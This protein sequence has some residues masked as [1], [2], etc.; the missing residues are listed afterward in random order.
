[1]QI[2]CWAIPPII[3]TA[4]NE[5]FVTK[6]FKN[7]LVKIPLNNSKDAAAFEE[8]LAQLHKTLRGEILSLEIIATGQNVGF[9]FSG[10]TA[11]CEVATGEIYARIPN[12]DIIEIDDYTSNIS[13]KA[14]FNSVELGLVKHDLFPLKTFEEFEGD[15][16]SGLLSVLSH[17]KPGE[18]VIIEI[19][20]RPKPDSGLHHFWSALYRKMDRLRHLFR[21]KYWFKR[22][23]GKTFQAKIHEKSHEHLFF[24]NIRLAALSNRSRFDVQPRLESVYGIMSNF[25]TTD[26][27]QLKVRTIKNGQQ[28]IKSFH[29]RHLHKPFLLSSRELAAMFHLPNEHASPNLI[30]ILASKGAPPATLPTDESDSEI[31]FFGHTNFRDQRMPFGIK[32]ADRHRHLHILGKSGYGKSKLLELLIQSDI[33]AGRGVGVLDPHGDLVDSVLRC[34]PRNRIEDVVIVDASDLDFP[35]SFNPFELVPF[36]LKTRVSL[37][38]VDIFKRLFGPDWSPRLEHLLRYTMLA[39]LDTPETTLPSILKMLSDQSYRQLVGNN[40]KDKAVKDFWLNEFASWSDKYDREAIAPLFNK[41]SQF[42]ATNMMHNI[43]GQPANRINFKEI[44]DQR[45]I[46][47]IKI[48]RGILGEDNTRLLGSLAIIK[49]FQA[50]IDRAKTPEAERVDFYLHLDEFHNFITGSAEEF[51][52]EARKYHLSL[53]LAHQSLSHLGDQNCKALLGNLGSLISFRVGGEDANVIAKE[54]TPRFSASDLINLGL[55]D[56]Y[57]KMSVDG[58]VKEPFSARTLTLQYPPDSYAQ[59]CIEHSRLHYCQPIETAQQILAKDSKV[60]FQK[61]NL[62]STS[63]P[64]SQKFDFDETLV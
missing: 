59:E 30:K 57:I 44:I 5:A 12:V 6:S 28:A 7:Y 63:R 25:N 37:G 9:Y 18:Q 34:V 10:S 24:A 52:T 51:L 53:T 40:I 49:L 26:Y 64:L 45:K 32:N 54:L 13:S 41:V 21:I 3:I 61:D 31:S 55:R 14:E 38:L 11:A 15:S 19:V 8:V 22:D 50:A 56:F 16:L 2:K 48:P 47:L 43:V 60:S 17:C 42:V 39:L 29:Q 33:K 27:N 20:I 1:M 4:E 46:L 36:E 58:E 23:T 35:P 62:P